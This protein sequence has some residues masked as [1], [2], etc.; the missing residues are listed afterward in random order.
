MLHGE[1][2]PVKKDTFEL[3]SM[4]KTHLLE[5]QDFTEQGPGTIVRDFEALLNLIGD[6]GLPATPAHQLTIK[7]LE[8]INQRLTHP[9]TLNLKRALQKSYPHI[10]GLYLLLRASGLSVI[11]TS[12]KKVWIKMDRQTLE[13]WRS[14]N[15]AER[16]FA[17][18]EAWWGRATEEIIGERKQRFMTIPMKIQKFIEYLTKIGIK[19]I[20]HRDEGHMLRYY[21]GLHN[22]A[23]MELF[24]LVSISPAPQTQSQGWEPQH[25]AMTDWG[26]ALVGSY[27]EFIMESLSS[28]A[29][30]D[31]L[32]PALAVLYD[33]IVGFAQWSQAVRPL[34]KE[35][36]RD[37]EI[38]EFQFQPGPQVF[39][40]S[41][42]K[43]CWRRIA[44]RGDASMD[45]LAAAILRAFDFDD[46]H[47]YR[48]S[49]QD[50]FGRVVE[51]DDGR[52][53]E[54]DEISADQVK[55]GNLPLTENMRIHFLYDFGDNWEFTLETE[56]VNPDLKIKNPK[57]LEKHGKAPEQYPEF[58]EDG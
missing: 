40:V 19:K 4:Q 44:I 23:L 21:P 8:T 43:D 58:N 30:L 33:P 11:E 36:R 13:S 42:A 3:T 12:G 28:D 35:W 7:T 17:L 16:Y 55:V 26:Q 56:R 51:I 22:L 53:E 20:Q 41:L 49:Y 15:E 37:L 39:K 38:A 45:D 48:F 1:I 57:V 47:L 18:L 31:S 2:A 34:I 24:G 52:L 9:L 29:K 6:Q 10:N 54:P 50:R 46:D 25:I 27:I 5:V 32:I 14:L